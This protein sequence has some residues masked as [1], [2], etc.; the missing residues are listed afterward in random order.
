MSSEMFDEAWKIAAT[1]D[2]RY[3]NGV[4]VET[5]RSVLDDIQASAIKAS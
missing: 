1:R 5:F 2:P 3:Q 4:S